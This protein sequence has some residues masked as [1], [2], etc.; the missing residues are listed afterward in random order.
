MK[1]PY[2]SLSRHGPFL[3][4]STINVTHHR[5]LLLLIFMPP[6]CRNDI[7][8]Y[9]FLLNVSSICFLYVLQFIKVNSLQSDPLK[10]LTFFPTPP[11]FVLCTPDE[12]NFLLHPLD[13]GFSFGI[14]LHYS[15]TFPLAH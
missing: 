6:L 15:L 4:E 3:L 2:V 14:Y 8:L 7:T 10:V 12:V 11:F 5:L 9:L 1:A 13:S